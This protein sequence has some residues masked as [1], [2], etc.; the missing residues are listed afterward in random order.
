VPGTHLGAVARP[1]SDG[2]EW[3]YWWQAHF[4]DCLLDAAERDS[5]S[6]STGLIGRQHRGIW[7]RNGMRF[8]NSYFDD[9]AWLALACQ[10]AGLST[11]RLHADLRSAVTDEW[12]GGAFWHRARDFK[13]T[14][15][16]GPIA[17]YLARSGDHGTARTLVGW[18]QTHL[19]DP[20]TGL[21]RDGLRLE[22]GPSPVLVPHVFTYNQGPILGAML[23]LGD[24]ASLTAAA[25]L[26]DDV[27]RHLVRPGTSVLIT[28]GSGDGG[29]FTGILTRY[30]AL[31]A[32][33]AR[34]PSSAREQ[35]LVLVRDTAEELWRG[36]ETRGW[37]GRPV[38]V[39][40][41][42]TGDPRIP[43]R[44]ELSTQL[45]AWMALEAAVRLRCLADG[46]D[47]EPAL[48]QMRL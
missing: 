39:F 43:H 6:V 41:S 16:T 30:L 42:D 38:T 28:H 14:A 37:R 23:A 22:G 34:L 4:L 9:M 25:E 47:V 24:R 11:G 21:V 45:Q 36:R 40:P 7:L 48:D 2:G 12:G 10:R 18:L 27:A 5:P 15:A 26:V 29:L 31:A 44:V 32:C 33:D 20:G 1:G 19:R 3:H 13:N 8:R 35:A 46:L 17:L